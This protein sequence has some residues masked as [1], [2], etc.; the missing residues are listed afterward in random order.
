[1]AGLAGGLGPAEANLLYGNMAALN[2]MLLQGNGL[3][4]ASY[5]LNQRNLL[6]P[7]VNWMNPM[8]N[9]GMNPFWMNADPK[10]RN[11]LHCGI[12]FANLW[13][14]PDYLHRS[15]TFTADYLKKDISGIS[16]TLFDVSPLLIPFLCWCSWLQ[17]LVK[18]K[19]TTMKIWELLKR[20]LTTC[21]PNVSITVG[22]Y[23]KMICLPRQLIELHRPLFSELASPFGTPLADFD[24][25]LGL[26]T[27]NLGDRLFLPP[28]GV[29]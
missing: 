21:R 22:I 2:P 15:S 9:K 25:M 11:G 13:P 17:D 5:L 1:M 14:H 3:M 20:M 10:V 18:K 12:F 19:R 7:Q 8:Q 6:H 29:L 23:W 28:I 4:K 26:S 27:R 16:L 24:S